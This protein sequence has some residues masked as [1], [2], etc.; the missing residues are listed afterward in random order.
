LVNGQKGERQIGEL[1]MAFRHS[2][3]SPIFFKKY[4]A[5]LVEKKVFRHYVLFNEGVRTP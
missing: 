4:F 2:A 5:F 1:K 3:F